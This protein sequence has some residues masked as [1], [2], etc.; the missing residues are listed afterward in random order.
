MLVIVALTLDDMQPLEHLHVLVGRGTKV[1]LRKKAM[2]CGY[3]NTSEF[4]RKVIRE[5]MK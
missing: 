2:E 1:K 4:V 5:A 3:V